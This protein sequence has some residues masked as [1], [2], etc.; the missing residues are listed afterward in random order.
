[1]IRELSISK[2]RLFR[3]IWAFLGWLLHVCFILLVFLGITAVLNP[4]SQQIIKAAFS[5]LP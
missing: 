5:F 1:M 2:K 3:Y 4:E